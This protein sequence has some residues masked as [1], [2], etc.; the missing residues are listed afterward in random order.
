MLKGGQFQEHLPNFYTCCVLSHSLMSDSLQLHGCSPLGSSVH[1]DSPGQNIL[2]WVA[3]PSSRGSSQP[4]DWTQVP[5]IA[6]WFFT[7][8]AT[9]EAQEYW[10][11]KPIPSPGELPDSGI[12]LGS[13]AWQADSLPAELPRKP[14]KYELCTYCTWIWLGS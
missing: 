13:P 3:M 7:I 9:R 10:C 4:R 6:G 12:E 2:E 8:W 11:G 1:G 5:S 14:C